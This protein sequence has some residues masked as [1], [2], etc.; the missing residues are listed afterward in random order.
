MSTATSSNAA[1]NY[2]VTFLLTHS[3]DMSHNLRAVRYLQATRKNSVAR[4]FHTTNFFSAIFGYPAVYRSRRHSRIRQHIPPGLSAVEC[5]IR[6]C[7]L[8][9]MCRFQILCKQ[10]CFKTAFDADIIYHFPPY[11]DL[12]AA[13]ASKNYDVDPE[14]CEKWPFQIFLKTSVNVSST[15]IRL[16]GELFITTLKMFWDDLGVWDRLQ[17]RQ[18]YGWK[19]DTLDHQ[20]IRLFK[21]PTNVAFLTAPLFQ[22]IL[23]DV[24]VAK[25]FS[26]MTHA[27]CQL[28]ASV[29]KWCNTGM[30]PQRR[31]LWWKMLMRLQRRKCLWVMLMRLLCR[32]CQENL[33]VVKRRRQNFP[34]EHCSSLAHSVTLS[35]KSCQ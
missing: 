26:T 15:V 23:S 1:I 34:H 35:Q 12:S 17:K 27:L 10:D 18:E 6:Q 20:G 9:V 24:A 25:R 13:F 31:N 4:H 8:A 7:S 29:T 30:R 14:N 5:R 11:L 22:V 33:G 21:T 28:S 19:K 3:F 16:V 32:N 2:R